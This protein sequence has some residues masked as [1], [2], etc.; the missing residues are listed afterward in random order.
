M[1]YLIIWSTAENYFQKISPPPHSPLSPFLL[2]SLLKIQKMQGTPLFA[3]IENFSAH[4]YRKGGRGH[5]EIPSFCQV[6]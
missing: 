3:N 5:Y 1:W 2:T 6:A 4:P